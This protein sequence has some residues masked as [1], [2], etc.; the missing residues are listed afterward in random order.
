MSK[1]PHNKLRRQSRLSAIQALYQMDVSG[2]TS[3]QVTM[4]FLNHRF[5][6]DDEP[7]MVAADEE[8]FENIV[9]GVVERQDEIDEM[10]S[11]NLTKSWTMKRLDMTLRAILRSGAYEILQRPDV[12]ALVIIDQYVSITADFHE[13]NQTGFVNRVL[14]NMAKSVRKAEFGIVGA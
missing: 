5:G 2:L 14:E 8:F 10:I 7:G 13:T 9:T 12:P 11:E 3:K 4:E 6:Y 1:G